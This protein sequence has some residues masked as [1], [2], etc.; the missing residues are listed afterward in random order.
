MEILSTK[1]YVG[2]DPSLTCSAIYINHKPFVYAS[3]ET[4]L[5]KKGNLNGWFQ[6]V[7]DIGGVCRTH[8]LKS[9]GS[10]TDEEISKM[11]TYDAITANIVKDISTNIDRTKDTVCYMEGYSYS[12]MSGPLIDLVTFGSLLRKRLIDE[13]YTLKIIPPQQL[14]KMSCQMIYPTTKKGGC[15]NNEGIAGGS[16]KKHQMCL[17]IIEMEQEN[18]CTWSQYLKSIWADIKDSKKIPKPV[19]DINDARLLFELAYRSL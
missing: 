9:Y 16:F 8:S 12:S 13:N 11:I 10:F 5:T 7:N 4:A 1:N 17:S 15:R 6:S 18:Y 14:K 3:E 2:I 19:E